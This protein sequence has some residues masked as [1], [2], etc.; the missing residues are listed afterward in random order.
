MLATCP[1][2]TFAQGLCYHIFEVLTKTFRE[3]ANGDQV[4]F[5]FWWSSKIKK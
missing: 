1:L 5:N 3:R 4:L 2:A